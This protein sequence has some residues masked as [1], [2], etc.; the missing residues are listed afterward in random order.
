MKGERP[1]T[2]TDPRS[3]TVGITRTPIREVMRGKSDFQVFFFAPPIESP[4][5]HVLHFIHV[6]QQLDLLLAVLV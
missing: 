6:Q 5:T 1:L 4:L 2:F 3:P